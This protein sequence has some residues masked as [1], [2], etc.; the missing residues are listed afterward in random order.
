MDEWLGF[1]DRP[2]ALVMARDLIK[3]ACMAES[4]V[5]LKAQSRNLSLM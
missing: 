4:A 3:I 2:V 1:E 5:C